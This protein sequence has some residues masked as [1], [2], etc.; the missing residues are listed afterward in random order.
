MYSFRFYRTSNTTYDVMTEL[1]EL[2]I[3]ECHL[4]FLRPTSVPLKTKIKGKIIQ[5]MNCN[6]L[7]NTP[8][9]ARVLKCYT[10]YDTYTIKYEFNYH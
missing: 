6:S 9:I 4:A 7:N 2:F 5:K 3:T 10:L 8:H 1:L